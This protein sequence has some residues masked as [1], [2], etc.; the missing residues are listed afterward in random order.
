MDGGGFTDPTA[1]TPL[2]LPKRNKLAR[3]TINAYAKKHIVMD[4][5]IGLVGLIPAPGA[6]VVA[7]GASIAAQVPV[8]YHPLV[9]K[10]GVIYTA[11]PDE[12][13]HVQFDLLPEQIVLNSAADITA[14]F[15]VE[16]LVSA[17]WEIYSAAVATIWFPIV[18]GVIGAILDYHIA[19]TMTNRV[20]R[21]TAL[22]YLNGERWKN[23][24][25]KETHN[26]A[27]QEA[28]GNLDDI[29]GKNPD[30]RRT[31]IGKL[32]MLI[33]MVSRNMNKDQIREM[34]KAQQ[35]PD[36]LIDDAFSAAGL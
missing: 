27:K 17:S 28:K 34:F 13:H 23:G 35:V 4:V 9:R 25:L 15:T 36:D 22:Y 31:M 11:P 21:M 16:F 5:G 6:A 8:V 24:S 10:L 30:V 1:F 3:E 29:P 12:L 19:K 14:D 33:N 7:L 2:Q 26:E 18:G 32:V 20:G